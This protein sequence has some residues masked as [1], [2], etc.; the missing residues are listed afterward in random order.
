[1]DFGVQGLFFPLN[2]SGE[3]SVH[4]HLNSLIANASNFLFSFMQVYAV[5]AENVHLS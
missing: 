3:D 2:A 5:N 1:M 4:L